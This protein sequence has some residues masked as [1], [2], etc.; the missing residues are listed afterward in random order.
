MI[1]ELAA[2]YGVLQRKRAVFL[3]PLKAL[4]ND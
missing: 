2:I 1:G 3:L 4:V